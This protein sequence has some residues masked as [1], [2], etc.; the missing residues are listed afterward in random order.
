M[1]SRTFL[2]EIWCRKTFNWSFFRNIVYFWQCSAQKWMQFSVSIHLIFHLNTCDN[3]VEC[4]RWGWC[5][6]GAWLQILNVNIM[7]LVRK[8]PY[9]LTYR[10]CRINFEPEEVE[11]HGPIWQT[12]MEHICV[13]WFKTSWKITGQVYLQVEIGGKTWVNVK[14]HTGTRQEQ[15]SY[16]R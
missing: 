13:E 10:G 1:P 15:T 9:P 3:H 14:L 8:I 16:Q 6:R 7:C 4:G 11:W 5:F 2:S 12:Y